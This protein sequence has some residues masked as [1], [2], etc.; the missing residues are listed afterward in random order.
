MSAVRFDVNMQKEGE[1]MRV[2]LMI[3]CLSWR[4]LPAA[5]PHSMQ[6]KWDRIADIPEGRRNLKIVSTD[7]YLHVLGGYTAARKGPT[8]HHYM[9]SFKDQIWQKAPDMLNARSNFALTSKGF[10]LYA[11]GGDPFLDKGEC[12]DTSTMKWESIPPMGQGRQHLFGA[13]HQNRIY[14]PGGL[15]CWECPK[16]KQLCSSL[17]CFD[18]KANTWIKLP[19]LPT[20]KQNPMVAVFGSTLLVLGGMGNEETLSSVE[21]LNLNSGTCSKGKNIPSREFYSGAVVLGTKII[22]LGGIQKEATTTALYVYDTVSNSWKTATPLPIPLQL[23]G[24]TLHE[25]TLYV[26]GGCDERFTPHKM[27]FSGKILD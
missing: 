21:V 2:V 14:V 23:A 27:A 18:L 26:V 7:N 24:F 25:R 8:T 3:L 12:F 10:K 19:D 11:I 20:A 4:I 17:D 5:A 6:I 15:L 13:L 1:F 9:Y 16:E 22:I